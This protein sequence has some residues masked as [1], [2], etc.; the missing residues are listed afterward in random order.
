MIEVEKK[1]ILENKDLKRLISEAEFISTNEF[2]DVYYDDQDYSLTKNDIWLRSRSDRFELKFPVLS[3][4]AHSFINL[5]DEI[6]NEPE[7]CTKLKIEFR[8]SL[9]HS[10]KSSGYNPFCS[11]IT[12]RT[13]Y[14]KDNFIIDIDRV[15]FG[16]QLAEIELQVSSEKEVEEASNKIINFAKSYG[17]K[18]KPIRGKVI[19]YIRRNN[20][21]HFEALKSAYGINL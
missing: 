17:L 5:Y 12:T 13:K 6:Y 14:K 8:K 3:E 7:M 21:N 4:A 20:P 9:E 15:D 1:F 2:T 16:Y 18:I 10:L 11:I 19:E